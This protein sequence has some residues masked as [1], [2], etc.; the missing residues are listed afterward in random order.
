MRHNHRMGPNLLLY[1]DNLEMLRRHV[2]D[3]SVDLIYLD[4]PFNSNRSYNILFRNRSGD[5]AQAQLQAFDDT[6][7]WSQQAEEQYDELL[8]KSPPKVGDAIEGMRRVL[9]DN[10]VLAYLVMMTPRLM[11]LHRVLK[12]TGSLYLHCDPTASHYLKVMMDAIFGPRSFRNEI[13]W[14]RTGSHG[15]LKSFGPLH[16]TILFYTKGTP[17]YFRVLRRPYTRRHVASRYTPDSTGKLKF[18]SGGNVLTGAGSGGGESSQPWRGFNPAAKNRHWAIPGFLSEQMPP[19]FQE[20]GV[21]SKLDALYEAGLIDIVDGAAWPTP[22]RYLESGDGTPIGDI[23]AYQPGTEK[24]LHGTDDGIDQDVAWLGP[25]DPERLGFPTQKPLGLLRRIIESSCPP[26][27][28]VLDPFCGCGTAILAAEE[29]GR[30]WIGIDITF[31]SID[32]IETRLVDRFGVAVRE[33]FETRGVPKDLE[34]ARALFRDSH[35]DFERWAVSLVDGQPKA[36]PGGDKGVDGIIRFPIDRKKTVGRAIVSVKGGGTLN[37]GMVRDLAGTV[38]SHGAELGLL[39]TLSKPTKGMIDE[40]NRSGIY[41]WPF[42]DAHFP[43]VQIISIGEMLQGLR[44]S[45]PPSY[46][47]YVKAG[48]VDF[49]DQQM[50]FGDA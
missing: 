43:K 36:K 41:T 38:K 23:W 42:N 26:E 18:T 19:E 17:Y 21:L 9:G 27:G 20:L 48:R 7:T 1:G 28:V 6:W 8:E 10:D 14:R 3:E 25:T 39:I 34:G 29:L 40:A 16:D 15:P 31:L 22:V 35:F 45:L 2:A 44:P 24:V 32:L 11:E 46:R 37:P 13:I 33:T 4:P 49:K 50:A 12:I 5:E 47:P 30:R